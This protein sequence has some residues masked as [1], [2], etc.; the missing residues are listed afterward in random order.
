MLYT[1]YAQWAYEREWRI[2]RPLKEG[3]EVSSGKF[4]F[5]VP[6][7][8]VRYIIFG[9]R[10]T[11]T[12]QTEIRAFIAANPTL[13]HVRFKSARLVAGGKIEVVEA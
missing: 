5:D 12:Q 1:K 11:P 10:T 2:I 7:N 8:A 4:C 13:S 9:C 6:A 3:T